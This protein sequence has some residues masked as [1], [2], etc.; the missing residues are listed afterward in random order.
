MSEPGDLSPRPVVPPA[1]YAL[2]AVCAVERGTLGAG[3][4][5]ALLPAALLCLLVASA[6]AVRG[7]RLGDPARVAALVC[8]AAL[9]AAASSA[10]LLASE[11]R[12]AVALAEGPVSAWEFRALGDSSPAGDAFGCWAAACREG[13]S[14]GTVWLQVPEPMC[15]GDRVAG[16]GSFEAA[17][18]DEWGGVL[19]RRGAAGTVRLAA[20]SSRGR[21][22]GVQGA[23][24]AAR[25]AALGR[26]EPSSS[27]ARA[28]LAGLVC[29]STDAAD[30]SGL[31]DAF[32]ACGAAHLVAVSGGHLSAIA[33]AL[34]GLLA[35]VGVRPRRRVVATSLATGAFVLFC[36]SPGSAVRSWLMCLV[37]EG[38][39]AAGRR[40]H[41]PSSV[42]LVACAM[43]LADPTCA[44][45]V[46][47]ELSVLSLMGL[48]L[49]GPYA[50]HA[51]EVLVGRAGSRPGRGPVASLARDVRSQVASTLVAQLACLPVTV[52]AFGR[53]SLV[54]PVANAALAPFLGAGM[55]TG[56]L[57][58]A[59]S[60]AP[61]A[62]EALLAATDAVLAPACAL[63]RAM[64]RLPMASVGVEAPAWV[65][66]LALALTAGALLVAWPEP[67]PA[68]MR[69]LVGVACALGL[70]WALRWRLFAPAR[71]VVLDVGQ[72]DA[73]LVQDGSSSLLVDAGPPEGVAAALARCHVTRLDLVVVTHMHDDHYGGLAELAGQ[74]GVGAVLV[75][76]GAGDG[77]PPEARAAVAS[78]GDVPVRELSLGDRLRC[79]GFELEVVSPAGE[80]DGSDNEDSLV[81][82]LTY[83]GPAGEL[84]ALLCGDAES[85]VLGGLLESDAAG[86]VDLLKAGHH[87]SAAS[88]T[89]AQAEALDPEVSVASAGRD[90][91]YGHPAPECREALEA[92]GSRF[93]CTASC[94]DVEVRPGDEGPSVRTARGDAA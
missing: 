26:I 61:V 6:A 72:G 74:A 93:L 53:V 50:S 35:R 71:V 67:R 41:G 79:G 55:G 85:D 36:G 81:L 84:E 9:L 21:A 10:L 63:A 38:A 49:F 46:G 30:A 4:V 68:P 80:R 66:W 23:L 24:G 18:D 15:L 3:A 51:L 12:A 14:A 40:A 88:L 47:L 77:M 48:G 57:A 87:G 34:G 59:L 82:A 70:A 65:L 27:D 83:D 56:M 13:V 20:V 45:D 89:R 31:T 73:I 90:N 1:T 75:G 2:A 44:S 29:A 54:A 43:C 94:G 64:A 91:P 11:S 7:S 37:S 25:R 60:G 22:P 39:R 52:G 5:P 32:T 58:V 76:E 8:T 28:L 69:M 16:A 78:L 42:A 92:V 33:T 17:G 86:D 19:R 62:S